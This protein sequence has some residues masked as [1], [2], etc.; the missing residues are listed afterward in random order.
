MYTDNKIIADRKTLK[1]YEERK[2]HRL[3]VSYLN[4]TNNI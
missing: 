4:N 2:S 3:K 1:C